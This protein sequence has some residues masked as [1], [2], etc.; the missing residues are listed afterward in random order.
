MYDA[1]LPTFNQPPPDSGDIT[2]TQQLWLPDV[3]LWPTRDPDEHNVEV[4]DEARAALHQHDSPT[5]P[6][7]K[8]VLD[9]LRRLAV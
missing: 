9:G 7:L 6:I 1:P 4:R 3:W 8:A 2:E 5:P